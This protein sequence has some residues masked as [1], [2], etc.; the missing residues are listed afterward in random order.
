MDQALRNRCPVCASPDIVTIGQILHS[1]PAYVAGVEIDLSND[2]Y[3]LR[4]CRQCGFQFKD[5]PID[6]ERLMACYAKASSDNWETDP[7]PLWRQFDLLQDVVQTHATGCRMLDVGCFNG[8]M[9]TYFGDH[10]QKFGIEPSHEA[11]QL[12]ES[13]GVQVLGP[14]I[15]EFDRQRGPFDVVLAID[16]VEHIVDPLPFFQR[17]SELLAPNG[18]FVILTGDNRSLAW[19]LQG[20]NYWYVSLPEHVSFYSR[21]TLDWI[22]QRLGMTGVEYRR[23]CHKRLPLWRWASDMLKSATYIGGR[24]VRGF[25][26]PALRRI[27]LERRGPSIQAAHDHLMYVYRKN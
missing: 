14:S 13:R 9:L 12:A 22:G 15:D 6:P 1:R 21:Q 2:D 4:G 25:G 23:L 24:A 19:R 5:P 3:W 17:V 27:F 18:V 26:V 11:A 10:W 20:A 7:D 8:A 16:V